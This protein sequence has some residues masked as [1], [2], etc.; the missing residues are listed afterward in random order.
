MGYAYIIECADGVYYSGST[1]DLDK[2]MNQHSTG[3]IG[4]TA[5]RRPLKL[6]WAM[7]FPSVREA[8]AF[9]RRLHGWSRRK[10]KA[11]IDGD[12]NMLKFLS[13][14]RGGLPRERE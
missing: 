1:V 6:V 14:R 4:Y 9:E 3:Q 7:E 5:K 8:Y 11:L 13:K 10:K 2:R 12:L